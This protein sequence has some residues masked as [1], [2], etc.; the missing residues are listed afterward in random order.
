M[1]GK[2]ADSFDSG[3]I[4]SWKRRYASIANHHLITTASL[5]VGP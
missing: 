1:Q 3:L 5:K 4:D 2:A